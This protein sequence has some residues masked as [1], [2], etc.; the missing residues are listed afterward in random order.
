MSSPLESYL[1]TF[2]SRTYQVTYPFL[3]HLSTHELEGMGVWSPEWLDRLLCAT[4]DRCMVEMI[5]SYTPGDL[6]Q[7]NLWELMLQDKESYQHIWDNCSG[8]LEHLVYMGACPHAVSLLMRT[9][10]WTVAIWFEIRSLTLTLISSPNIDW[11]RFLTIPEN[12]QNVYMAFPFRPLIPTTYETKQWLPFFLMIHVSSVAYMEMVMD[13]SIRRNLARFHEVFHQKNHHNQM[14]WG[15][16]FQTDMNN[17]WF[18]VNTSKARLLYQTINRLQPSIL[19]NPQASVYMNL[20]HSMTH[21]TPFHLFCSARYTQKM[22]KDLWVILRKMKPSWNL[23]SKC[24]KTAIFYAAGNTF[25][26]NL[27]METWMCTG[28]IA[29]DH[30]DN[31][32]LVVL[33]HLVIRGQHQQAYE[34]YHKM[35]ENGIEFSMIIP[36]QT[37]GGRTLI[38]HMPHTTRDEY[39]TELVK[40][41]V[42][43][44]VARPEE[45]M[46]DHTIITDCIK[47]RKTILVE[48]LA[49]IGPQYFQKKDFDLLRV[50][51]T[52]G[53][54]TPRLA[55][56]F[57]NL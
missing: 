13:T 28:S 36:A 2:V 1:T 48:T 33:H 54:L 29:V 5:R 41:V 7:S 12:I 6:S 53:T 55:E 9:E 11:N 46:V 21:Q 19:S 50:L 34:L 30:R 3:D 56:L 38:H 51:K 20:P 37:M 35:R 42:R 22:T 45:F 17:N 52:R 15:L 27:W 4:F 39:Y 32:G 43:E 8:L 40:I 49:E 18:A 47:H 26:T 25:L 23:P 31:N 10:V 57:P 16:V 24:G 14:I 44:Y